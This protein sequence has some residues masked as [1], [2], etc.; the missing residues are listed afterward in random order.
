[1]KSNA[2]FENKSARFFRL[3]DKD[4]EKRGG[5]W[6]GGTRETRERRVTLG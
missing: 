2:E 4:V 3:C 6:Y 1:M 5:G